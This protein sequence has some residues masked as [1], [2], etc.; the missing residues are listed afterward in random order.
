M[1]DAQRT[2]QSLE[3]QRQRLLIEGEYRTLSRRETTRLKTLERE[4]DDRALERSLR[5][6]TYLREKTATDT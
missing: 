3:D 1:R 6:W 2:D 4:I 5:A